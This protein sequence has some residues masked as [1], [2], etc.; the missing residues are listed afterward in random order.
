MCGAAGSVVAQEWI[1]GDDTDIYFALFACGRD[2]RIVGMFCGR[3]LVCEP[4]AVGNTAVCAPA[5]PA[6]A[7]VA[8]LAAYFV[9]VSEYRGIG[10]IEFKRDRRTGRLLIVE[11]TVGRTDWQSEIATLNGVNLPLLAVRDEL[12]S[13]VPAEATAPGPFAAQPTGGAAAAAGGARTGH[14]QA[15]RSSVTYRRPR[16]TLDDG[17]RMVDGYF[18]LRDPLPGVYHYLVDE[19][20]RRAARRV[21]RLLRFE[22]VRH[23]PDHVLERRMP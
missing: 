19:F 6:A 16:G 1:E 8:A 17:V 2:G 10:G 18:R 5:G 13:R 14:P 21:V 9:A 11:P 7:E 23:R 22:G 20:A 4:P 3:K 12:E 15:W